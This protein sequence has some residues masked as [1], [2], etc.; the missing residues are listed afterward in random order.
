MLGEMALTSSQLAEF[1]A[2]NTRYYLR[3]RDLLRGADG[4]E[5][6]RELSAEEIAALREMLVEDVLATLSPEQRATVL[7]PPGR[8][9][10]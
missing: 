4:R 8:P 10:P 5:E 1:R 2:I 6:E 3:V 7:G 9:R